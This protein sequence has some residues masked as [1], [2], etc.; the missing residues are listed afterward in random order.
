MTDAQKKTIL[1]ILL[2]FIPDVS[3]IGYLKNKKIGATLYNIGHSYILALVL[4]G[5]GITLTKSPITTFG[6]ILFAHISLDRMLG[7]GIKYPTNFKHT[8]MQK[9]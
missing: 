3:M 9:V 4:I 5:I 7:Y 1:F 2:F 6:I 8:H